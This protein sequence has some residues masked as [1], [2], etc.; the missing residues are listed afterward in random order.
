VSGR[1]EAALVAL[2]STP[3]AVLILLHEYAWRYMVTWDIRPDAPEA[4]LEQRMVVAAYNWV[5]RLWPFVALAATVLILPIVV[6]VCGRRL[7]S[8]G[9]RDAMRA[10][11]IAWSA[12]SIAMLIGTQVAPRMLSPHD[13]ESLGSLLVAWGAAH[14]LATCCAAPALAD[15]Y[16]VLSLDGRL[17]PWHLAIP[18]VLAA[19]VS[20]GWGIALLL[21]VLQ[22]WLSYFRRAPLS[23]MTTI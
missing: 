2:A 14:W 5:L 7:A 9:D 12:L 16:A 19:V 8:S 1:K 22:A 4:P 10:R 11:S 3:A 23:P 18:L 17:P 13:I 21:L 6:V 15:G 20:G